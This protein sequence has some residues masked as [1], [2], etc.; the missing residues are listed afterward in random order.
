MHGVAGGVVEAG[1]VR[2]RLEVEAQRVEPLQALRAG[3]A[4]L[5]QARV[6]VHLALDVGRWECRY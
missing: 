3:A 5:R 4:V 1:V 6:R 2:Q